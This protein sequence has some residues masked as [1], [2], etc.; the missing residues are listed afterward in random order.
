NVKD[1][2]ILDGTAT[3]GGPFTP[4]GKITNT[5]G[6]QVLDKINAL[7][8]LNLNTPLGGHGSSVDN[9]PVNSNVPV[10]GET[11]DTGGTT[12]K[13][14]NPLTDFVIVTRVAILS[15]IVAIPDAV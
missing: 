4:F 8:R 10:T 7:H 12:T 2:P 3:G 13:S 15:K 6:E 11:A 14:L 9:F 1:N 5:S